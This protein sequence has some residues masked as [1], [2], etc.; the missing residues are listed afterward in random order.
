MR[1]PT[2]RDDRVAV[3]ERR[4]VARQDQRRREH[5]L[6]QLGDQRRGDRMR[7]HAHADR[8]APRVLEPPRHLARRRQQERVGARHALAHDAELPVVEPR[9]APDLREVAAHERQVMALVDAADRAD[10]RDRVGA[11]SAQPSA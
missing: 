4:V 8:A 11:P 1:A 7:G 10:A 3:V 9:V 6:A 2:R 5:R